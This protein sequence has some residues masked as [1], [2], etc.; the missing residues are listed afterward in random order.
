MPLGGFKQVSDRRCRSWRGVVIAFA[1]TALA[2]S[3]ASRGFHV[4]FDLSPGAHENYSLTKVQH[5]DTDASEWMSP[6][7][8]LSILWVAAPSTP[9]EFDEPIHFRVL[10]DTLYNR[11]PPVL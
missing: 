3:L 6:A 10:D 4:S 9:I 11:P 7:P 8:S 1:V 2:I 5:R